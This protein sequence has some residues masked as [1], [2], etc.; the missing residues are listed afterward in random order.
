[1]ILHNL[2]KFFAAEKFL[3]STWLISRCSGCW[4]RLENF[5]GDPKQIWWDAVYIDFKNLLSFDE[6]GTLPELTRPFQMRWSPQKDIPTIYFWSFPQHL[7]SFGLVSTSAPTKCSPDANEVRSLPV[8][9]PVVLSTKKVRFRGGMVR[10]CRWRVSTDRRFY[11]CESIQR[12][13]T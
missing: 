6:I 10:C 12:L 1:M 13:W 7:D 9:P 3:S 4:G 11:G 2:M 5:A 8:H